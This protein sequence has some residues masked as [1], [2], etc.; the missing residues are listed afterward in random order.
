M[1]AAIKMYLELGYITKAVELAIASYQWSKAIQIVS[2][3]KNVV[4]IYF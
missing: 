2:L 4:I 1:D 3:Q